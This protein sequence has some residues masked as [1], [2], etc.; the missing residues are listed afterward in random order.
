MTGKV[1]I[2]L[3]IKDYSGGEIFKTGSGGENIKATDRAN[4]DIIT[5]TPV[6]IGNTLAVCL[7]GNEIRLRNGIGTIICTYDITQKDTGAYKTILST[8]L[9]YIV[10]NSISKNIKVI[11]DKR[12]TSRIGTTSPRDSHAGFI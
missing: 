11:S 3:N 10:K 5:H 12:E 1:R 9:N 8:E 4:K 2:K 7:T 6:K